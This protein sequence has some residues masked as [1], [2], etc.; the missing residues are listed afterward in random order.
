[1]RSLSPRP[2]LLVLALL[3]IVGAIVLLEF[4][5]D[6]ADPGGDRAQATMAEPPPA[7]PAKAPAEARVA[8]EKTAPEDSTERVEREEAEFPRAAEIA[9]PTGF[10]NTDG[11]SIGENLGERVVLVEFWTY[12]CYNCQNVQ[13]YVNSWHEEYADDGLLVIGVHRPEFEF[14][15][16]RASVEEAVRKAGIEYPVVLDNDS[17]TWEAYDNRYWPAWYLIDAD[18]FVRYR[19]FGEG[20]YDETEEKIRELLKEKEEAR[21]NQA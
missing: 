12:T 20:A 8:A 11:I 1:M 2:A 18:G 5:F 7:P 17:A 13:P 16:D 4:G 21:R 3:L 6:R 14:E 10:V 9:N 15:K 19:H